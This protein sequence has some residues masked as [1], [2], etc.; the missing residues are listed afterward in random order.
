MVASTSFLPLRP[1]LSSYSNPNGRKPSESRIFF[2]V[3]LK[4]SLLM[5]QAPPR[6]FSAMVF[7]RRSKISSGTPKTECSKSKAK[8]DVDEGDGDGEEGELDE[9]AFEALFSQL[10]EDLKNDGMLD[11]DFDDEITEEDLAK[12][13]K[14]FAD[15]LGIGGGDDDD[16]D[17][18]KVSP[19]D[20]DSMD[21]QEEEE[22]RPKLKNWQVRRLAHA[23]KIG[24]RKTS[25]KNLSAELGL[26][27]AFVLELLRDPPANILLMSSSLPDKITETQ[28]EPEPEPEIKM[29]TVEVSPAAEMHVAKREP[30]IKEPVHVMQTRWFMQ[31][32]LK[33]VQVETLERV[34]LRT[35]RPTNSMINSIVHMTNLPWKRVVKWFE[36]KR[37]QDGIPEQRVPYRRSHA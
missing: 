7:A 35:K 1:A 4:P 14:E 12:L 20:A 2:S 22:T 27:R 6:G 19:T 18:A 13:E 37:L 9:D 11:D 3:S 32:R 29:E 24:R 33:K 15:A 10:E 26:D 23:L 30:E 31:K 28:N 36:D 17:D 34:Y 8:V 16:D 5:L 25:I 21:E